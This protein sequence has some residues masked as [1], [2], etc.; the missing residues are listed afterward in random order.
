MNKK[1]LDE[2]FHR[3]LE[4]KFGKTIYGFQVFERN[5]NRSL[6]FVDCNYIVNKIPFNEFSQ[7]QSLHQFNNGL[8]K[9]THIIL[10]MRDFAI[11]KDEGAV[12][13]DDID[14]FRDGREYEYKCLF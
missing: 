5:R 3:Y 6:E 8:L 4:R 2:K 1:S 7:E 13:L 9:K 12:Y 11:S 14:S 10:R